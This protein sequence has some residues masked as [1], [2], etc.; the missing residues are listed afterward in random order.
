MYQVSDNIY[1]D[2]SL[3]YQEQ[4]EE[5]L[6]YAQSVFSTI[7]FTD[8]SNIQSDNTCTWTVEKD[9]LRFIAKRVFINPKWYTVKEHLFNVEIL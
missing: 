5:F 1:F 6:N 4:S 7:D 3:S 2:E 9:G 8:M